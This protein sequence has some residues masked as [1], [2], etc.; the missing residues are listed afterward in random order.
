L[1]VRLDLRTGL[2]A[3]GIARGLEAP[4][5]PCDLIAPAMR[6]WR[7]A[8]MRAPLA[9]SVE[10]AWTRHDARAFT[11]HVRALKIDPRQVSLEFDERDVAAGGLEGV[12]D[13]RVRGFGVGLRLDSAKPLP[14]DNQARRAFTDFV[15]PRTD[16][17]QTI[18]NGDQWRDCPWAGRLLIAREMQIRAVVQAIQTKTDAKLM[19]DLG[20]DAAEGPYT[21]LPQPAARTMRSPKA[22][23]FSSR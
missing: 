4:S 10:A 16:N 8:G 13:L 6:A 17:P 5:T 11:D 7:A 14:L 18:Y 21:L 3:A 22:S 15:F 19:S 1:G 23:S 9:L 12:Q 2:V 20:F